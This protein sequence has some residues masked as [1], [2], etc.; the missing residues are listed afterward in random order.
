MLPLDLIGIDR[1]NIAVPNQ[2]FHGMALHTKE[3]GIGRIRTPCFRS[4]HNFSRGYC[5]QTTAAIARHAVSAG[6]SFQQ[7]EIYDR[8]EPVGFATAAPARA[9]SKYGASSHL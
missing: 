1:E 3:A 6:H 2:R 4:A 5:P 7:W 9:L 8:R